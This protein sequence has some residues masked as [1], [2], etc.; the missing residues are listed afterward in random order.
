MSRLI[1][2][3]LQW[4]CQ[5]FTLVSYLQSPFLLLVRLYWGWQL[6]QSGWGKLH[7]L[8]NV[9]EYFA[10]LGLPMPAQMA[11]F[12]A[13]VEFFGGI[14]LALGLAS[15][16]TGMVLT[17]N[18]TMAYLIGDREALLSFFSDPDKFTAAAPFAFL[19]VALIVLIFDAGR[20]SA[21]TAI[22][23]LFSSARAKQANSVP[24]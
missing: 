19:M 13:C 20:I 7:H 14:F 10:T 18:L 6:A 21:D 17:V 16:I 23:F 11:V 22:A 5:F 24:A 15:R 4:H 9:G 12:I 1:S 8:S 3:A 2:K